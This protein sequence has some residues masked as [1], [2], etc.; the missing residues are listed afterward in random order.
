MFL[1]ITES[2]NVNLNAVQTVDCP[3]EDDENI[4]FYWVTGI[5]DG[6]AVEGI[7]YD[8]HILREDDLQ[9]FVSPDHP[10]YSKILQWIKE[11]SL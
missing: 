4:A 11:N 2:I 1:Q 5:V 7:F 6:D 10:K 9:V 3:T 8:T